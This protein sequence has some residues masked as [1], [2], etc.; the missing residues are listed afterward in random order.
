VYRWWVLLHI[1][2]VAGFLLSH[3]VSMFVL[4]RIREG[5][6]DRERIL[7][8]AT[9]SGQTTAPMYLFLAM[10]LVGGIAAGIVGKWFSYF[11]IWGALI[12][13]VLTMA[14]M[15]GV[16]RPYFARVKA[17]CEVRPSGV[18]RVSDEELA[19]ILRGPTTQVIAAIGGI[20]L[21]IILYFM[22]FKP[23]V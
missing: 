20:G 15:Y 2:G 16:A 4:F 19:Q 17:A 12:V 6:L 10:L 3:G 11:W 23:G 13:L 8:Y 22:V 5:G 7:D 1:V 18:P 21:L 9:L 14:G